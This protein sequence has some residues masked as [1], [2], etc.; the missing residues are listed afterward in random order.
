MGNGHNDGKRGLLIL[1]ATPTTSGGSIRG[2]GSK[3]YFPTRASV[4][5][6]D[7]MRADLQRCDYSVAMLKTAGE[8]ATIVAADRKIT[9]TTVGLRSEP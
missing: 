6:G 8:I 3:F 2:G 5:I 1:L 7:K 9:L 4:R